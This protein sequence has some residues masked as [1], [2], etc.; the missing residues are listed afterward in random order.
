MTYKRQQNQAEQGT[1]YGVG[2]LVASCGSSAFL[3]IPVEAIL[4]A[5]I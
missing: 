2:Y 1:V 4:L 5:R 3:T